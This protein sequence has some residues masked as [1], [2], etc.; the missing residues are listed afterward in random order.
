MLDFKLIPLGLTKILGSILAI[1]LIMVYYLRY[2]II[3]F[4]FYIVLHAKG[5]L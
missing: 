5:C 4:L 1:I 3:G 2:F